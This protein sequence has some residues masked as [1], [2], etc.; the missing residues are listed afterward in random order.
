[1]VETHIS[2]QRDDPVHGSSPGETHL[3]VGS[4][5]SKS[6]STGQFRGYRDPQATEQAPPLYDPVI[7]RDDIRLS[8]RL[9]LIAFCPW[10]EEQLLQIKFDWP[11]RLANGHRDPQAI[12]G[13]LDGIQVRV[14]C[15]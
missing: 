12:S 11:I 15:R 10:V 13:I 1:M 8:V 2:Y 5:S 7:R 4:N 9:D 3:P 6:S 14:L